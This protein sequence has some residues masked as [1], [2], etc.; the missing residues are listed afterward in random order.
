MSFRVLSIDFA[1]AAE[2]RESRRSP[3]YA[4][5]A[6]TD[7]GAD[8]PPCRLCLRR[9]RPGEERRILF[10]YDSFTASERYP[11]PGPVFI[12]EDDCTPFQ[13]NNH[14]PKI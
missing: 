13:A 12:H 11:D 14:F 2:V 5:P 4:H 10:T 8:H 3:Q 1:I 7:V 9:I 6:H